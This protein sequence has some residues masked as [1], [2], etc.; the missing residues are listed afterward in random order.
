MSDLVVHVAI[1]EGWHPVDTIPEK[2][3]VWVRSVNGIE[4]KAK[5]RGKNVRIREADQW[6]PQRVMCVRPIRGGTG[7][8]SAIAWKPIDD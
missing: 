2:E 4:C 7:D 6:G 8:I 1:P 5:T 3:L